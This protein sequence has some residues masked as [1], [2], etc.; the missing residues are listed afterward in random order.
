[1]PAVDV[2]GPCGSLHCSFLQRL[3]LQRNY[4]FLGSHRQ[5]LY[6][7]KTVKPL[8][9]NAQLKSRAQLPARSQTVQKPLV[10]LGGPATTLPIPQSTSANLRKN[11]RGST[12][13]YTMILIGVGVGGS[14]IYPMVSGLSDY[15]NNSKLIMRIFS[16]QTLFNSMGPPLS[17]VIP[18][19]SE[20]AESQ[21][22]RLCDCGWNFSSSHSN[23]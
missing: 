1:M 17:N 5:R 18:L 8:P 3:N 6:A 22:L 4:R 13:F 23:P 14:I 20:K 9:Y 10:A 7:M 19:Q 15:V 12:N 11:G 16:S 2:L 21:P